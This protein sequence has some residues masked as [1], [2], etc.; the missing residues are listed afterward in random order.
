MPK[1]IKKRIPKKTDTPEDEV[2]EKLLSLKDTLEQRQNV[3]L[4]IGIGILVIIIAV[5]GF[6]VYSYTSGSKAKKLEYEAYKIYYTRSSQQ[7]ENREDQYR[8][9]LDA[10]KKAYDAKQSPFSLYYIAACYYELGQYDESLKTLKD[11][12]RKYSGEE[13]FLP[14]AYRKMVT[15]YM[16]KG[17]AG[18]TKKTLDA[19]YNL[20]GDIY[21]DFVLMEYGRILEKEGNPDEARKKY[22]ELITRFPGSPFKDE[23]QVKVSAK[24]EG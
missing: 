24:K 13:N 17:D 15:I 8:K 11:F 16:R 4:K 19:L 5:A 6:L 21:K 12:T 9:A 3:A 22:E 20:K 2:Q 10:F 18:E 1:A 23:A 7:P 14:L